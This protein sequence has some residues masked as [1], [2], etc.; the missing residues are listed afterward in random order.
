MKQKITPLHSSKAKLI[1]CPVAGRG[2]TRRKL[3]LY[4]V[5]SPGEDHYSQLVLRQSM[6]EKEREAW[7]SNYIDRINQEQGINY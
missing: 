7:Y 1:P 6:A 4:P 5:Q 3:N 2:S